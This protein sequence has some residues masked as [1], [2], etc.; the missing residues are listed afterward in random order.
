M[1]GVAK[2]RLLGLRLRWE[3]ILLAAFAFAK[4]LLHINPTP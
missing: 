3:V 2:M 4:P 1:C